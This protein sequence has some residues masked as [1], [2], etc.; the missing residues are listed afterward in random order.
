M[1]MCVGFSKSGYIWL[2][3]ARH[4]TKQSSERPGWAFLTEIVQGPRET[5]FFLR[6]KPRSSTPFLGDQ[7]LASMLAVRQQQD[8]FHVARTEM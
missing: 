5:D 3:S 1:I 8:Q 6:P 4:L 7:V 2:S